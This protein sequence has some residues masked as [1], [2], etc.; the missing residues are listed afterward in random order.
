MAPEAVT[1]GARVRY[2]GTGLS[3]YTG[4][5]GAVE[6]MSESGFV[7]VRLDRAP[8]ETNQLTPLVSIMPHNLEPEETRPM[9]VTHTP[10][11]IARC[12]Q[13]TDVPD[14]IDLNDTDR[15]TVNVI[16]NDG[17]EMEWVFPL[18][19]TYPH[20][21]HMAVARGDVQAIEIVGVQR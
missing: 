9:I 12:I 21:A 11:S 2:I 15:I 7:F 3:T 14:P 20:I 13:M 6:G 4:R 1:Y 5:T 8:G 16:F 10:E 17:S 18:A 19:T